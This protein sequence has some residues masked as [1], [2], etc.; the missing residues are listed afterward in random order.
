MKL[1]LPQNI[2]ELINEKSLKNIMIETGEEN[3]FEEKE[4]KFI[5]TKDFLVGKTHVFFHCFTLH[6]I[7][8]SKFDF[9]EITTMESWFGNCEYLSEIVFPEEAYCEKLENLAGCFNNTIIKTIDLSFMKFVNRKNITNI[10]GAFYFA[11][12]ERIVLP[13][14]KVENLEELFYSCRKLEE[15]IA[16]VTIDE[17]DEET[18]RKTFYGNENLHVVNLSGGS[19]NSFEFSERFEEE[20]MKNHDFDFPEDCIVVLPYG[21]NR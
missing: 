17:F 16:P 6:K 8:I 10:E 7:D 21:N 15:I 12:A 5:V 9:S 20:D 1:Y 4:N 18:L 14:I 11:D 2:K 19:F 13:K 3:I